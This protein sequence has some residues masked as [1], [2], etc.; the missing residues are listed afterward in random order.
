MEHKIQE[1]PPLNPDFQ[2]LLNTPMI[3]GECSSAATPEELGRIRR[4]NS[5]DIALMVLRFEDRLNEM[6]ES[7]MLLV[8]KRVRKKRKITNH[9]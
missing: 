4:M 8:D 1:P 5:T 2:K 3:T 9:K 6:S 7:L